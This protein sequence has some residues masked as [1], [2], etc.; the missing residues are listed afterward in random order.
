MADF[1]LWSKN[2]VASNAW[3]SAGWA[4]N[5]MVQLSVAQAHL[6]SAR[7]S[8]SSLAS[9]VNVGQN[10]QGLAD[11]VSHAAL[12]NI[13]TNAHHNKN[14]NASHLP[15]NGDP[16]PYGSAGGPGLI[17]AGAFN[18]IQSIASNSTRNNF[19][20]SRYTG[21][22]GTF[23]VSIGWTPLFVQLLESGSQGHSWEWIRRGHQTIKHTFASG[24]GFPNS[25]DV[26]MSNN[27]GFSVKSSCNRTGI[28]YYFWASREV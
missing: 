2:A 18:K 26:I 27:N 13:T 9:F 6:R 11:A 7:F 21:A 23:L 12:G 14:H 3:V 10:T 28:L 22:S 15:G 17:S 16:L 24:H 1:P 20:V 25:S 4:T 19:I 5:L 8:F